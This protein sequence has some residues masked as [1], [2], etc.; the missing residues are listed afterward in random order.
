MYR[1][2]VSVS[3]FSSDYEVKFG[4]T[5]TAVLQ[6]NGFCTGQSTD[7]GLLQEN[8]QDNIN[9]YFIKNVFLKCNL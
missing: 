1:K 9:L 5:L 4:R 3:I 2:L 6:H 7:T 8:F